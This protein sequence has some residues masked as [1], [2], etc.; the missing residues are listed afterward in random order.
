MRNGEMF[1]IIQLIF[2][3]MYLRLLYM[4]M[5]EEVETHCL[6]PKVYEHVTN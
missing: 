4:Y 1:M 6:H 2:P 5:L 3:C